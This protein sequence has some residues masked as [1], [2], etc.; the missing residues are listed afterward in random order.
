MPTAGEQLRAERERQK[1]TIH[2]VANATNIKTDHVRA[3]EESKWDAFAAAVYIRGF[4]R[5]Y[6]RFL[7]LD[8]APLI[9]ILE[10]ELGQTDDYAEPPS[11][12]GGRKGSLDFIML[13][14]S[15]VKW[16][17][18]FPLLLGTGIVVV[19]AWAV[20]TWQ[21]KPKRDPLNGLGSGLYQPKKTGSGT[22]AL[23]TNAPSGRR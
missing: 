6:A 9:V 10:A 1:L 11:L 3:L 21:Q 4:T 18:V 14:L 2:D 20:R 16:Q 12:D 15:R 5:T 13:Q 7:K 23:P 8:P 17:W 19:G 22:L